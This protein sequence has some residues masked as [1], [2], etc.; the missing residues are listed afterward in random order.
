MERIESVLSKSKWELEIDSL[1]LLMLITSFLLARV[2][3]LNNLTP[4]GIAFLGSRIILRKEKLSVLVGTLLGVFSIQGFQGINYY[5]GAIIIYLSFTNY[6]QKKELTLIKSSG[7]IAILFSVINLGTIYFL[8]DAFVYD[9]IL[10]I[11]E[12]ILVFTITYIF[13]FAAPFDGIVKGEIVQEKL[14]C[15]FITLA[16]ILSGIGNMSILNVSI[17]N[18]ISLLIIIHLSYSKGIHIGTTAG[19]ILGLVSYVSNIE[20]PFIIAILGIGGLLSGLFRD[21][22]KSGSIL[23]FL[24]G[25]GIISYYI[26]G[27]GTSFL[28]YSELLIGSI[29]FILSY[30]YLSKYIDLIFTKENDVENKIFDRRFDLASEKLS[31]VSN[32]MNNLSIAFSEPVEK[33]DIFS[34]K[35]IY[36]VID[37]IHT[38]KCKDCCDY[39]KCWKDSYYTTYYSLFTSLGIMESDIDDKVN[40]VVDIM[41]SCI[42]NEELYI[43]IEEAYIKYRDKIKFKEDMMN[44]QGILAEQLKVIRTIIDDINLQVYKSPIFNNE[45]EELLY[46]EIKNNRIDINDITVA[47]LEEDNIEVHLGFETSNTMYKAEKLIKIVSNALG[48]PVVGDYTYGSV[49]N[50]KRFKLIRSNRYGILTKASNLI[51]S[52]D[53]VSGD[54]FTFG[55]IENTA[56]SAISDGMGIGEEASNQSITTIE[57]LENMME[58][59]TDREMALKTINSVIRSK[60]RDETFATLDI[61]FVDLF[62]GRL[63]VIKTGAPPTFIKRK[64]KVIVIDSLS[65]PIGIL[66]DVD[67]NIYEENIQD[68]DIIIMMSDGVLESNI[69]NE[70]PNIWMQD[71]IMRID[72]QNPQIIADEI[73]AAA[74]RLSQNEIKDDMTVVVTKVW[75]N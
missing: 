60:S 32:L 10:I 39:D 16:L 36:N 22:G 18:I 25:N 13:L 69:K 11:F 59:N 6:E 71:L 27:L 50:S 57:L 2:N 66:K 30:K 1:N 52:V 8:K 14:I 68:G 46:K 37:E 41:D 21:I 58:I 64:D 40:T 70:E 44:H 67:F 63:Q 7:I 54:S 12:G 61:S 31:N 35:E 34:T 24:L 17:K 20:M 73:I 15:S 48:Y 56:F 4:F 23:G 65:L 74:K 3:I 55:E 45:L 43:K 49:S 38:D 42:E 26:N 28:K 9:L 72:S 51:C 62:T 29:L 53:G 5:I 19:V 33:Q 75:K 47:Y